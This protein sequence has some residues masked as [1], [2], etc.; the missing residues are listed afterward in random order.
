MGIGR[1]TR[2]LPVPQ[3]SA[4]PAVVWQRASQVPAALGQ[5]LQEAGLLGT[6]MRLL[7]D[8]GSLHLLGDEERSGDLQGT[9]T[10]EVRPVGTRSWQHVAAQALEQERPLELGQLIVVPVRAA[11]SAGA[12]IC[13]GEGMSMAMALVWATRLEGI[14]IAAATRLA[15]TRAIA[16]ALLCTLA[17][18]HAPSARHSKAVAALAV[19][20][21]QGMCLPAAMLDELE[22]AA[23]L[24]DLGKVS[25]PADVLGGGSKLTQEQ[26]AQMR[27]HPA[28]GAAIVSHMPQLASLA[29]IIRQHHERWDGAGYPDRMA[30]TGIG[31]AAR[32]LALVDACETMSSGRPYCDPAD[33]ERVAKELRRGLSS[34]F[35]PDLAWAVD[36]LTTSPLGVAQIERADRIW[37]R[38]VG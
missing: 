32:I 26:W 28:L 24:H 1:G 8:D 30:G 6:R 12:L 9:G 23:L 22:L 2:W 25:V 15:E 31:I 5:I 36:A 29:P 18:H 14:L 34:Q 19:R 11:G 13:S 37:H 35:D 38:Q 33:P 10:A 27:Q 21:G 20:I 17:T 16:E 4:Q 3:A 7:L